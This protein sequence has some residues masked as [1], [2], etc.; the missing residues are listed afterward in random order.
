MLRHGLGACS[1]FLPQSLVTPFGSLRGITTKGINA[2]RRGLFILRKQR[3]VLVETALSFV[4]A[5]STSY[6]VVR[7]KRRQE[8]SH[9]GCL[10][11][12][13]PQLPPFHSSAKWL[14][15]PKLLP[16]T[17]A[18]DALQ[19][20]FLTISP[21]DRGGWSRPSRKRC[22]SSVVE[23]ELIA[24]WSL[25]QA[26]RE[27]G[28]TILGP[29]ATSCEA[30]ELSARY[31]PRLALIDITLDGQ[32]E[33]ITL[34]RR[35]KNEMNIASVFVTGQ[36]T[37]ARSNADAALGLIEKPYLLQHVS[38]AITALAEVLEGRAAHCRESV[39]EWFVGS[40]PSTSTTA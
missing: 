38:W 24:A 39:L 3:S 7:R 15:A 34:A 10:V 26:L 11:H 21:I 5:W 16:M 2:Q 32:V 1:W 37:L 9:R 40:S 13:S 28:H 36:P 29:T 17:C 4:N 33:G 23:D 12:L 14:R 27:S 30:I 31:A 18:T 6:S 35:L 22:S 8:H 19:R 25:A 20:V